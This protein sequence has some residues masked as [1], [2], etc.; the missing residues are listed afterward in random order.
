MS[1]KWTHASFLLVFAVVLCSL[2]G[3]SDGADSQKTAASETPAADLAKIKIVLVGASTATDYA[4]WGAGFAQCLKPAAQCVNCSKSGR[5][6]KSYFKEGWWEKALA[7]KPDYMLIQFGN[8]DRLGKGPDRETDPKTTYPEYMGRYIDEAHAAGVQPIIVTSLTRR[9]FG[10][11]G[12]IQSSVT[13]YVEAAKR[14]AAEK[15]APMIDLHTL[16][17]ALHE[18]QGPDE[19]KK[20]NRTKPGDKEEHLDKTHLSPEGATVIGRIVAEELKK[21]VPALAPYIN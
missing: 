11:D 19:T 8:N 6:S 7:E 17:I 1:S 5:S 14:V 12:K 18:K 3:Q 15:H 2:T 21:A 10:P 16:S 20:F 9:S 4:G 13:P